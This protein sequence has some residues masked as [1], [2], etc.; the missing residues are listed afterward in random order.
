MIGVDVWRT[1]FVA[2][3]KVQSRAERPCHRFWGGPIRGRAHHVAQ[4]TTIG[5]YEGIGAGPFASDLT[6]DQLGAGAVRGAI[7]EVVAAGQGSA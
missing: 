1:T 2:R 4:C 7:Y 5:D 6:I 3:V